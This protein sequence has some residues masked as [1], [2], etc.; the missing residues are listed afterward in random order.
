[1]LVN[2]AGA[3]F[4][5]GRDEWDPDVFEESVALNL[6]G[7]FRLTTRCREALAVSTADG[8]ECVAGSERDFDGTAN[9]IFF[10]D[11]LATGRVTMSFLD[12][13]LHPPLFS[14]AEA[15]TAA[16]LVEGTVLPLFSDGVHVQHWP[17]HDNHIH[18]RVSE[19]EGS[20]FFADLEPVAFEPP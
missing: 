2:N 10:G 13:E 9:A 8:R 19:V 1:M 15:A 6:S 11:F 18:I 12:V 5:G 20:A 4:P 7:A 3:N 16:G 14:G 17:N